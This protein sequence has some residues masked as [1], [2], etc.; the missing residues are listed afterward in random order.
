MKVLFVSRG[1]K[2]NEISPIVYYQGVSLRKKGIELDYF[3][4]K[5]NGINAYIKSILPLKKCIKQNK[6]SIIHSH[7]SLSAITAALTFEKPLI[8]SLMG[9][10]IKAR[11]FLKWII[12]FFYH[13]FWNILIVKSED[14]KLT[15]GLKNVHVIPNGIDLNHF[16]PLDRA[17]CLKKIGWNPSKINILFAANPKR[18]EKNYIL[19]KQAL[20]IL[21]QKKVFVHF[22]NDVPYK[23]MPLYYNSADIVLLTSLWEGSPNVIK[24][25][26]ACNCPIVATNVGDV[27]WLFG[28]EP[29]CFICGFM[30]YDVAEKIKMALDFSEEYGR[31][32]GWFRIKN[33]GLDAENVAHKIIDLYNKVIRK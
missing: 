29:G 15:L 24:E 27:K 20:K 16:K 4:I 8:V 17:N 10:D 28:N 3:V 31:T 26:M 5:G 33:L 13:F 18:K 7:Y 2:K 32:N 9:S 6:Y 25:A 14:M 30:P 22:L 21:N 23:L 11:S 1:N 12:R 19:A